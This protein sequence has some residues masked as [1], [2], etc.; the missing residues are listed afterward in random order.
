MYRI[1]AA[2]QELNFDRR[3]ER[4]EVLLKKILETHLII[5]NRK[6]TSQLSNRNQTESFAGPI[7]QKQVEIEAKTINVVTISTHQIRFHSPVV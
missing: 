5:Q 4:E 6:G 3:D 2:N 1:K 7:A